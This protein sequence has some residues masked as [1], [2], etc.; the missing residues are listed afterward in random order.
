MGLVSFPG[1]TWLKTHETLVIVLVIALT[2][3][4]GTNKCVS[5]WSQ[6]EQNKDNAQLAA[7]QAQLDATR[8]QANAS[9]QQIAALQTTVT[10]V[11]SAADADKAEA[12]AV[13]AAL[14]AQNVALTKLITQRDAA[15]QQQQ[16]ADLTLPIPELAKRFTALVPNI[17]PADIHVAPDNQTVTIGKDTAEK[18]TAR[19]ELIPD[20]QQDNQNLQTEVAA[21][22]TALASVQK[23]LD[24]E[25][26]L[27]D[28]QAKLIAVQT[29]TIALLQ[30][31]VKQANGVCEEKLNIEKGKT[32]K[33]WL[34]GFKWGFIG[35]AIVGLVVEHRLKW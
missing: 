35:G 14:T 24:A 28:V 22:Q 11:K 1:F 26:Q 10:Q 30:T 2:F 5:A 3:A 25:S 31:E 15:T 4:W 20:L 29:T 9:L 18:T 33:A 23:A 16:A 17:N 12:K 8:Q 27:A 13:V 7:L 19:L 32:K 34:N 21:G 6:H